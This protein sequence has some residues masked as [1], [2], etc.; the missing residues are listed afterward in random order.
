MDTGNVL[1]SPRLAVD[2]VLHF[3]G[4][5]CSV[6]S[7]VYSEHVKYKCVV[8]YLLSRISLQCMV[9]TSETRDS[10]V[11]LISYISSADFGNMTI[12]F[13]KRACHF[14]TWLRC[15]IFLVKSCF[16][17]GCNIEGE[18]DAY[19]FG[20]GAGF[21]VDATEPKWKSNYRMYSYV[22]KEVSCAS[23]LMLFDK[24]WQLFL[25]NLS[26]IDVR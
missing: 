7:V 18:D 19:D 21:Y 10:C 17:G 24:A 16:V 13:C 1:E 6:L 12:W 2:A 14:K 11:K 15:M 5:A 9:Y 3:Y 20:S 25:H 26:F 22:T 8:F 23:P 4:T